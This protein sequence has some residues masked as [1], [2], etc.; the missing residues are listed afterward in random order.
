[1]GA[2]E[3][4]RTETEPQRVHERGARDLRLLRSAHTS[5]VGSLRAPMP[6]ILSLS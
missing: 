5:S 3:R 2:A 4:R 6:L 1:M